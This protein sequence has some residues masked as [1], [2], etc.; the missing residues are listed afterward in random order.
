MNDSSEFIVIFITASSQDEADVL[1]DLLIGEKVAA[2]VN[3]APVNSVFSWKGAIERTGEIQLFVKT[4]RSLFEKVERLI[5]NHHSYE[6]PEII[7]LPIVAG[8]ESY[9]DWMSETTA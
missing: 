3:T 2:C 9:L 8:S 4:K 5:K 1:T 6:V 7:A